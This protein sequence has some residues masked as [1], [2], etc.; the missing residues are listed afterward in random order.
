MLTTRTAAKPV[1]TSS[2]SHQKNNPE[3]RIQS[4]NHRYNSPKDRTYAGLQQNSTIKNDPVVQVIW[5]MSVSVSASSD[6][7]TNNRFNTT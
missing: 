6:S 3:S 7:G 5:L 2:K 1:W 4:V